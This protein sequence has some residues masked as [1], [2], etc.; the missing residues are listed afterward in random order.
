MRLTEVAAMYNTDKVWHGYIPRYEQHFAS[1]REEPVTL[2]EIGIASGESMR[3][4]NRYF[5]NPGAEF[6]GIDIEPD[7]PTDYDSRTVT[8]IADGTT[9]PY[10]GPQVDIIIDDG[11]HVSKDILAAIEHWWKHL[12]SGGWYVIEDLEV[13]WRPDYGGGEVGSLTT[14]SLRDFMDQLLKHDESF[15]TEMHVY[16]EIVFLRKA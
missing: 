2:V 6:L 14:W 10:D 12:K 5:V 15:I 4:W 9:Y 16:N 7:T 8:A 3:M 13:Q 11:S 1:L